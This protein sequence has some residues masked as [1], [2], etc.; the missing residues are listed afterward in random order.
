MKLA[1]GFCF[2]LFAGVLLGAA[3]DDNELD[4]PLIEELAPN[5]GPLDLIHVHGL[6]VNPA[7]GLLYVATHTGLFRLKDG[8]PELVGKRNWDV[9]GFTVRGPNDFIGGGHPS[10]NE[11]RD[12]KYPPLLGFI[13]S[14]DAAK[15]WDILAMKG[16]ADLHALAVHDG[17]IYAVDATKGNFLASPDGKKWET[18]SQLTASSITVES[19]GKILATTTKGT[20]RSADQGRTWTPV[21]DAPALVLVATQP[22]AGA[23]GIDGKG[24]VYQ[25]GGGGSWVRVGNVQGRP[26]AFAATSDRLFAATDQGIFESRDGRTWTALYK[27]PGG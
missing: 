10:P 8:K 22:A 23:W 13:Q 21:A 1:V 11:I 7:D 26:E 16:E 24:V 15:N 25:M 12:G 2:A 4:K 20:Q 3:C 9:M 19:D 5:D 17:M 6:G 18:R 27:A 14:K